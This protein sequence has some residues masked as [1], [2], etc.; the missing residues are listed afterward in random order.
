MAK[1]KRGLGFKETKLY[2]GTRRTGYEIVIDTEELS[3]LRVK[4]PTGELSVDYYNKTRA[5]EH[6]YRLYLGL[7]KYDDYEGK[8]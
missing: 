2:K 4:Y 1:N 7:K 8:D 3:M 6:S 5:K